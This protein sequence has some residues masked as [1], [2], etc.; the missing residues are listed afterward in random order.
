MSLSKTSTIRGADGRLYVV[1]GDGVSEVAEARPTPV[2]AA[3][4]AGDRATF[5]PTDLESGRMVITSGF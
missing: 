5:D 2:R 3:M 4:R 1:T